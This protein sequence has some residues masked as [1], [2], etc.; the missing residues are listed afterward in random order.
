MKTKNIIEE[1][2]KQLEALRTESS[3]ALNI[4]TSTIN[5]LS[6]V[7]EKIDVTISEINEAKIK[8]SSTENDLN[9]TKMHN[10]KIIDKFK[11]LIEG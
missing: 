2:Q 9:Q 6:T 1:K 3:R 4:V 5:S 10:A 8:L 7:N 11:T